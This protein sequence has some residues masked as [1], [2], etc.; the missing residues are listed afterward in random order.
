VFVPDAATVVGCGRE[1]ALPVEIR[2]F[3]QG[4]A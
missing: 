3:F 2:S 1:H 4:R